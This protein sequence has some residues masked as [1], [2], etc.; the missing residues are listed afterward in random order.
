VVVHAYR[1]EVAHE[2]HERVWRDLSPDGNPMYSYADGPTARA[3]A[4]AL[5]ELQSPDSNRLRL[6]GL[7]HAALTGRL[8]RMPGAG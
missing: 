1:V 3:E 2:G 4:A 7:S 6:Q 8:H 5:N